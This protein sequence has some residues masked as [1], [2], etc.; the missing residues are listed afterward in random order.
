MATP[1]LTSVSITSDPDP[2]GR[3]AFY[4]DISVEEGDALITLEFLATADA[5][6]AQSVLL[7]HD[8][9]SKIEFNHR[10][11]LAQVHFG[12]EQTGYPNAV[13]FVLET[14]KDSYRGLMA[15]YWYE[16]V[17]GGAVFTH[18]SAAIATTGESRRVTFRLPKCDTRSTTGLW[19]KFSLAISTYP[20]GYVWSHMSTAPDSLTVVLTEQGWDNFLDTVLDMVRLFSF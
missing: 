19:E 8:V 17:S 10:I 1:R 5:Q 4:A 14:F 9:A 18:L 20:N 12:L 11:G 13:K 6:T 15:M 7:G 16:I 2:A 3:V